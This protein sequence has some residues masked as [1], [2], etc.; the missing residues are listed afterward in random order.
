MASNMNSVTVPMLGAMKKIATTAV[1]DVSQGATSCTASRK[2][3]RTFATHMGSLK[4]PSQLLV[5]HDADDNGAN[6]SGDDE[7][8]GGGGSKRGGPAC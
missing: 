5:D 2:P 8:E 7:M 6:A 1:R 4:M 3:T